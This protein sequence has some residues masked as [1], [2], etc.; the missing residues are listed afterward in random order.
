[1]LTGLGIGLAPAWLAGKVD[2][3]DML[4][5]GGRTVAVGGAAFRALIVV[6]VALS[7][8]LVVAATLFTVS[9]SNLKTQSLGFVADGVLTVTVDADGTGLEEARLSEAHRQMLQRLQALPGVQHATFATIPPLSSQRG[10]QAA[11]RFR[12][13]RS[14]RPTTACCR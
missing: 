3:R 13:W 8:V 6:Q 4:S 11:S 2:L 10:W 5:A 7:T 14:R 1:M 12:A 9:L